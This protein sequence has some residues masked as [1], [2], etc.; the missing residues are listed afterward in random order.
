MCINGEITLVQSESIED[1][2]TTQGIVEICLFGQ[3]QRLCVMDDI[4]DN[5]RNLCRFLGFDTTGK[6]LALT[7]LSLL[8]LLYYRAIHCIFG[9]Y[10]FIW[11]Y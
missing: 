2:L 5:V 3:R 6:H 9:G 4:V 7:I 10:R 8:L 11:H 1:D